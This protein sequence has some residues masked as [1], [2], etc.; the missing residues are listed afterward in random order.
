MLTI[1]HGRVHPPGWQHKGQCCARQRLCT[2]REQKQALQRR[3]QT[4]RV[5]CTAATAAACDLIH[6]TQQD[7][8]G[9][10]YITR[11]LASAC[12]ERPQ[13]MVS[14]RAQGP[15]RALQVEVSGFMRT[16]P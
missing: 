7:G 2:Q 12:C 11:R 15:G 13:C 14:A 8:A 10:T 5:L 1:L 4:K 9:S 3:L 16:Q 6:D